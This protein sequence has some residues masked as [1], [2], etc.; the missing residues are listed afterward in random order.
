MPFDPGEGDLPV[1]IPK[2][3]QVSIVIKV[4][5]FAARTGCDFALEEGHEVVSIKV[6]FEGGVTD[7]HAG[8]ELL[9]Y[10]GIARCRREGR[11]P[12]LMRHNIIDDGAWLDHAGPTHETG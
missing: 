7:L 9:L 5:D 12:I 3:V 1:V 10:V 2:R 6:V 11:H 8:E 4:E